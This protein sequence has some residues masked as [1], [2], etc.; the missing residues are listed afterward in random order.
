MWSP[1]L[2]HGSCNQNR[3]EHLFAELEEMASYSSDSY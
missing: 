2:V 1:L 3:M